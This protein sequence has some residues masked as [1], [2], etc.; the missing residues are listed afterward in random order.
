M[1]NE[2]TLEPV[3]KTPSFSI[4]IKLV[5]ELRR[6]FFSDIIFEF[7]T[8]LVR[9]NELRSNLTPQ[10]KEESVTSLEPGVPAFVP[11]VEISPRVTL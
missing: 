1:L 2:S 8:S 4:P 10:Y 9:V 11:V 6:L 5:K 3:C 7:K